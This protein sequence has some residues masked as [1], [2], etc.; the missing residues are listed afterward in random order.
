[1]TIHAEFRR[2]TPQQWAQTNPV[3]ALGEPGYEIGTQ[4][5]KIGNGT[6]AWEDLPYVQLNSALFV[7]SPAIYV[8]ANQPINTP[9]GTAWFIAHDNVPTHTPPPPPRPFTGVVT[10][11]SF[12][13]L[14]VRG[15]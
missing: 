10:F 14:T 7:S 3:L 13:T 15:S 11:T 2:G 9:H 8:Q 12:G 6:T 1:M 4:L 5:M